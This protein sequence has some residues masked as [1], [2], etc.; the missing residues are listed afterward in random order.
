M[1]DEVPTMCEVAQLLKMAER[2]ILLIA[3]KGQLPAVKVGG[4]WALRCVDL[5]QRFEEQKA[6]SRGGEFS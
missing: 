1:Q 5:D 4:Q 3:Q 2:T 6:A